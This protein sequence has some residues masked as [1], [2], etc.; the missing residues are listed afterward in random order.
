M[1]G[2]TFAIGCLPDFHTIGALAPILLVVCR[3]LQGFGAGAEQSGGAT[4]LAE[5]A[6]LGR[7]GRLSSF[8]MV[9]A[10]LGAVLGAGAWA[11]AQLLPEAMLMVWG[12]RA[13]R[14]GERRV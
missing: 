5:T 10:A 12:W 1:G 9:G 4:L 7:R 8:V 13:V 3:A 6:P 11:I 2:A 14:S